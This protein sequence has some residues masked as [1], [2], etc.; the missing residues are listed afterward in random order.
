M[1]AIRTVAA[2]LALTTSTLLMAQTPADK[3]KNKA[4]KNSKTEAPAAADVTTAPVTVTVQAATPEPDNG[5]LIK[6]YVRPFPAEKKNNIGVYPKMKN[7]KTWDGS[8]PGTYNIRFKI[9]GIKPGDT[10]FLADYHF[11]SKYLRDTTVVDKKGIATFTG[12]MRLQRGMYLFVLPGKA[13]YFEIMVD[14]DQDFQ[15]TTDTQYWKREYYRTMKVEGS[16]A[17]EAF[18]EYQNGRIRI[19]MDLAE[20][21]D[22]AK[23]D[24]LPEQRKEIAEKRK[25]LF[26]KRENYDLT[27]IKA[28]PDHLLSRFLYAMMDVDFP[29]ELPTLPDGTKDSSFPYRYYKNHF[30]DHVDLNEDGL[31]RMPVNLLKGKIDNYFDK[32][33]SPDPDSCIKECDYLLDK[34]KNTIELEKYFIYTLTHR[35]ESSNIMGQDAVFVHL[36]LNNYCNGK[37]WWTDSGTIDRM[38]DAAVRKSATLVGRTA[39][40]LELMNRDSAWV[41]TTSIQGPYT[42]MIFWDPTCGH[43]REVMPKLEKIHEA[44]KSKGWQVIALS[45]G[46]KKPEWYRYMKEH[47]EMDDFTHLLRGVVRSEYWASQMSAY[48]IYASPTI[49]VLDKNKKILANRIDVEKLEEFIKHYEEVEAR[50]AKGSN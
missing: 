25:V 23:S 41:N 34:V 30:W 39:P 11:D 40:A 6:P 36:A 4:K 50:K 5:I 31:A 47:P 14:D 43:C 26:E 27:Y 10:V 16:E 2:I 3:K 15:I 42:I 21:E 33:V 17:N 44:N 12:N 45:S 9:N 37:A 20:L 18:K 1:G 46:E 22:R 49:F 24:T 35:F 13:D 38:C 7:A 19:G 32:M 48:Y 8:E 28:Y 29:K